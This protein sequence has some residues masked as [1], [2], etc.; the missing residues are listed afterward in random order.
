MRSVEASNTEIGAHFSGHAECRVDRAITEITH[1]SE[2]VVSCRVIGGAHGD[3]LAVRLD[4]D[5]KGIVFHTEKIGRNLAAIAEAGVRCS[6]RV[7]TRQRKIGIGRFAN[8]EIYEYGPGG[9]DLAVSLQSH[10]GR[11]TALWKIRGHDAA[12]TKGSIERSVPV[13]ADHFEIAGER[14]LRKGA[15]RDHDLAV[16]LYNHR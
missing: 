10:G 11:V 8:N 6:I 5:R 13:V 1:S 2:V 12:V 9:N 16:R 15:A 7:V 14:K 4:Q 3:N